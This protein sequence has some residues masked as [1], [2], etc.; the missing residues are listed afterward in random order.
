MRVI[1]HLV[2]TLRDSAIFNPEV[3][4]S[5]SCI[6][7]PDKDRQWEA[8][9]P[10][11]QSELAE[12]LVL[13]EYAPEKRVG[14]AIWL[15][16]VMA[17]KAPDVTLPADLV[18]VFYLPGVSRQDLRAIEDC[19][20]LLKPLA[21]LQYRGVIWSQA[22]AKDWTIAAFLKS[23]QG[24]IGLDVAQDK[25]AR[26]AMHLS[27][28]RLLDEE[29]ELLKGKRLGKDYFNTLLTGGDPVR[30]LLQWL[31]LGDSF[32][33]TRGAN[34]W[35][36]FV[37]VCKSQLAFNPQADGV[38]AGASKLAMGEGAWHSVWERYSE[39]PR[40]YPNIPSRI[41]QCKPPNLGI[42]DTPAEKLG[43]WPQWNEEQEMSL[44]QELLALSHLPEHEARKRLLELDKAHAPRREMVW[45]EL[46]ESPLALAAK[47]LVVVAE[48]TKLALAAGSVADLQA[49]YANQGW[50]ADDA[51]LSALAC[52]DKPADVEAVTAAIRATYLPWLEESARYLQKIVSASAY[53]G[54]GVAEAPAFY[55]VDGQCVLFV[56]GL[57]FDAARRLM[58]ALESRGCQVAEAMSW[59]AL[60]SVTATGKAA[61]SPV[62][63][64]IYGAEGC[65]DFEPSVA[66]T[67]QSLKGGYHLKKLLNENQ[68]KVL[69]KAD[70]GNGQGNA[71][72]ESGDIDNEGHVRGWKLAKHID[73]LLSEIAERIEA[74][75]QAGW[76]SVKVVTDH[77]WLLM[78]GRLPTIQMS[79]DLTDNKWG[80]C[81]SIKPGAATSERLYPWSWNPNQQFAL[82]D[83]VSCYGKS[84]D[85][86]HGGLSLQ[87]CLTLELV[88]TQGGYVP[89]KPAVEVTDIAWKGLRCTVGVEGQY[90]VL[91]LD[92]RT[93]AGDP[94]STVVISVKPLKEHGTA[95][96]VVENE[97]LEGR[98]AFVVLLGESGELVAAARTVIGGA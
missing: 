48:V 15:R 95:S 96:V 26:N 45:A 37:E 91:S 4:V 27:L 10:R 38:L 68:W 23:D 81:A 20:D 66:A 22:N 53:P 94:A 80:R 49:G 90:G 21:E 41:R 24:G 79:K 82:A 64:K 14:P 92:I 3:Q 32:Q 58:A 73:P 86:N 52:V 39:A 11:L 89:G 59:S 76:Q 42:F 61:V 8:V 67:G 87:E 97:D 5:P 98:E 71:W 62:R 44:Q 47:H 56:D 70:N 34:E 69:D 55:R 7:W 16:C 28:Y 51:V 30:D 2:K 17:G 1:E 43:G 74:L 36:A 60:P 9:I 54:G 88:V 78:P 19:P 84:V 33:T 83:G 18:P 46:G 85:Y 50:R 6:L 63:S 12:L 75:L 31:D 65:D 40:R 57:R 35:K 25:E 29:I 13:G 77:G 93:Q 72:C